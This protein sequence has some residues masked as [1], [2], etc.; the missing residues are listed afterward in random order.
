[1]TISSNLT[2]SIL[3]LGTIGRVWA[4]H[5]RTD[6]L[7]VASWNRTQQGNPQDVVTPEE[8]ALKAQVVHMCLSDEV[9]TRQIVEQILPVLDASKTVVQ[10]ATI[11]PVTSST[12]KE[13][14]KSRGAVY[15]EC[16]FTG[17]LPAAQQR[18]TI[19]YAGGDEN[20]LNRVRPYLER[21]SARIHHLPTNEQACSF[22]LI[23]NHQITSTLLA[24][25]EAITFARESGIS[26]ELF[27]ALYAHHPVFSKVHELKLDKMLTNDFSTQFSILNM[28]K[29][30]RLLAESIEERDFTVPR[31]LDLIR[32]ALFC[33]EKDGLGNQDVASL[34]T[35]TRESVKR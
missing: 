2:V 11:D 16:P 20:E 13:R 7:L 31:S 24:M 6:G 32:S 8:A 21:L 17:S 22:K 33:V 5:M 23:M 25:A 1:M 3:G 10:S 26:D 15:L 28:A 34:I 35:T 27:R 19:F 4:S 30:M 18:K 12:I 14:V 9:I 29:D